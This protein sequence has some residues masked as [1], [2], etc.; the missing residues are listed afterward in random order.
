MK[1]ELEESLIKNA[2]EYGKKQIEGNSFSLPEVE[3]DFKNLIDSNNI[4]EENNKELLEKLNKAF[5]EGQR[6]AI[7]DKLK[8]ATENLTK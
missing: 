3:T 5:I 8:K 1:N 2:F 6:F 7:Q 4:T